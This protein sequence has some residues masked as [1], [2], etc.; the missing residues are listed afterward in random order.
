MGD[1]PFIKRYSNSEKLPFRI[2][3]VS[4]FGKQSLIG[5]QRNQFHLTL[6]EID[7]SMIMYSYG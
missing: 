1:Y 4:F 7:S 5:T 2:V 3:E 6:E